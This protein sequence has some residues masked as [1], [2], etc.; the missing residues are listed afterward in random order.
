M[1]YIHRI[2]I[3]GSQN[4]VKGRIIGGPEFGALEGNP[5]VVYKELYGLGSS[6]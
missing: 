2:C 3:P 4:Q 1:G 6:G 5:L